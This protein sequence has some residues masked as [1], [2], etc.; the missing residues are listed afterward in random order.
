MHIHS[1]CHSHTH[2]LCK[3]PLL[4]RELIKYTP[5]A[6]ADHT[7]LLETANKVNDGLSLFHT[8][9]PPTHTLT[10]SL[11]LSNEHFLLLSVSLFLLLIILFKSFFLRPIF[12]MISFH[13][14]CQFRQRSQEA[15]GGWS[16]DEGSKFGSC[17]VCSFHLIYLNLGDRGKIW[18]QRFSPCGPITTYGRSRLWN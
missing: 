10:Y 12:L 16:A 5:P 13:N 2:S 7:P 11:S 9:L 3:Y 15:C 17:L 18:N 14:S 1:H 6:H 4:L 8:L